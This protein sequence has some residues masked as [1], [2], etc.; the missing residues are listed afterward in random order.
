MISVKEKLANMEAKVA[1]HQ[2][3]ISA[4]MAACEDY[5]AEKEARMV[6]LEA[7]KAELDQARADIAAKDIDFADALAQAEE[8][9]MKAEET[10]KELTA[11]LELAPQADVSDGVEPVADGSVGS[12][13]DVDHVAVVNGLSGA[14][15]IAYYREHKDKI[16]A[17]FR[18]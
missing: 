2:Q 11:K 7:V 10:A 8:A 4:L 15:K 1:E 9:R 18:K 13:A 14:E 17:A 16:D 3:E 6:E 5:K 12:D